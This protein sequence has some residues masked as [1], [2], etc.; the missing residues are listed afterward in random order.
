VAEAQVVVQPVV[1]VGGTGGGAVGDPGELRE[2]GVERG[3]TA[4]AVVIKVAPVAGGAAA[5]PVFLQQV[6]GGELRPRRQHRG[7][8]VDEGETR[9]QALGGRVPGGVGARD[10]GDLGRRGGGRVGRRGRGR[11]RC[12]R[13]EARVGGEGREQRIGGE[14][15]DVEAAGGGGLEPGQRRRRIARQ[16]GERGAVGAEPAEAGVGGG[17]PVEQAG[18]GGRVRLGERGGGAGGLGDA[19]HGEELGLGARIDERGAGQGPGRGQDQRDQQRERG[20]ASS[21]GGLLARVRGHDSI[22]GISE[23]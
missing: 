18:G 9:R 21:Q 23:G 19:R 7:G 4:V 17:E 22:A 16:H 14:R 6:A 13:P 10:Q 12:E 15:A 5:P 3:V 1:E 2:G 20:S 11:T 8:G